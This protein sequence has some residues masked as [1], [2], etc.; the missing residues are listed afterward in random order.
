MR[1]QNVV[2]VFASKPANG[3]VFHHRLSVESLNIDALEEAEG[4]DGVQE[5]SES[6]SEEQS[7]HH[8][9]AHQ[10]SIEEVHQ[11]LAEL[12]NLGSPTREEIDALMA[13]YSDLSD[14]SE[15]SGDESGSNGENEDQDDVKKGNGV[16]NTRCETV[17]MK[18][19]VVGNARC[20]KTSTIR[21]FVQKDFSEEYVSTIGADFVEKIIDYDETL[22]ISLQLWDIAGQDRFAKLTR[23]YFRDTK[24]AII[25]CDIT[26]ANT[27]DAV[28]T[29]KNELDACCTNLSDSS[30][31]IPV[32]MIANKSD[33][34]DDPLGALTIGVNMQKCVSSNGIVEWFRTS[35]KNGEH[36]DDAFK[37]LV[38][39]MVQR[40][41]ATKK[42]R[43]SSCSSATTSDHCVCGH[44]DHDKRTDIIR[45]SQAPPLREEE[46]SG[47]CDCN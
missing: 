4:T 10:L 9:I 30:E 15:D 44:E 22:R 31:C 3:N 27:I 33:L 5:L 36:V 18:V 2:S 6:G 14:G 21:R 17:I 46:D 28:V 40:H 26:R 34:L 16:S 11:R 37:C 23:A 38:D 12:E 13:Q 7:A 29:W 47:P 39:D 35:A 45:L 42:K 24:G 1:Q 8:P 20:G 43:S 32:V 19:V 41:R 25:V